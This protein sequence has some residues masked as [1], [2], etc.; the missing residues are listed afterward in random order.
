MA[1]IRID[2]TS[3]TV[4]GGEGG[5]GPSKTSEIMTDS[6]GKVLS[7]YLKESPGGKAKILIPVGVIALNSEGETS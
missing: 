1:D 7:N 2:K 4:G 5:G 3:V 6:H